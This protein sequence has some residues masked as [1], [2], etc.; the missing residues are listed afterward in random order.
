MTTEKVLPSKYPIKNIRLTSHY[1]SGEYQH[2]WTPCV[3]SVASA[4]VSYS[5]TLL[6]S[7]VIFENSFSVQN[8]DSGDSSI[9]LLWPMCRWWEAGKQQLGSWSVY[10]KRAPDTL[11]HPLATYRT[12]NHSTKESLTY[13]CADRASKCGE[14]VV[15]NSEIMQTYKCVLWAPK[16]SGASVK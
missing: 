5:Q 10:S 6:L 12:L 15:R 3:C 7:N 8:V 14:D 1:S 9:G 11:L 4:K 13:D 2:Y 16:A